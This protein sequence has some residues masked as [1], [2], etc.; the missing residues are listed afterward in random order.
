MVVSV[1]FVLLDMITSLAELGQK[2]AATGDVLGRRR[3]C[4]HD[5]E[6]GG[7]RLSSTSSLQGS[8]TSSDSPVCDS[9]PPAEVPAVVELSSR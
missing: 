8:Q 9:R 5:T 4:F 2:E 7:T 3:R 1:T 6:N